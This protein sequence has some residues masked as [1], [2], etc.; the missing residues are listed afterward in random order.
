MKLGFLNEAIASLKQC[1]AIDSGYLNCHQHMAYAYLLNGEVETA[2]ELNNETLEQLFNSTSDLFASTYVRTGHRYLALYIAHQK[3]ESK[4]APLIE[5][6]RAIESPNADNSAGWA[7]LK[8]WERQSD[9]DVTLSILPSM[10]LTYRA[11]DELAEIE[12]LEWVAYVFWH[13]DGDEFRTTPQFKSVIREFGVYEYWK[14]R[15][16]PPHCKPVGDNDFECGRP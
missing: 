6:I 8:D 9:R 1:L 16:F 11:Y 15:G 5:W 13:P 7:R 2:L 14:L 12:N 3:L 4:V 10:F